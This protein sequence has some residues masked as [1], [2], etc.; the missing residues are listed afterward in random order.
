MWYK[1]PAILSLKRWRRELHSETLSRKIGERGKRTRHMLGH[2][3]CYLNKC[4]PT[5]HLSTPHTHLA[6]SFFIR[7]H[8]EATKVSP[9][10]TRRWPNGAQGQRWAG[11][12]DVAL[13]HARA[14]QQEAMQSTSVPEVWVRS[15]Y[16]RNRKAMA[17]AL[18]LASYSFLHGWLWWSEILQKRPEEEVS[19]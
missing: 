8:P 14:S 5:S 9:S 15:L 6:M 18:T 13:I 19:L 11:W 4:L 16:P 12:R 3:W 7:Y 1:R 10:E 17:E 2:E